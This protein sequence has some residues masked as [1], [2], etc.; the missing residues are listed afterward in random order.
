M[1]FALTTAMQVL[2]AWSSI[3]LISSA[4][5]FFVGWVT[6]VGLE[7]GDAGV[8]KQTIGNI[9]SGLTGGAMI[10]YTSST[11]LPVCIVQLHSH[12]AIA[13]MVADY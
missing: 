9:V 10:A 6:P 1:D 2:L 3:W 8:V 13:A 4:V 5:A 11:M 7:D 12:L